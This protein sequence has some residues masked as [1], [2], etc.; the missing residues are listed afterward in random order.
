[1]TLLAHPK[2]SSHL[3]TRPAQ[4]NAGFTI[5][6]M[7][8][9][10]TIAGFMLA[11]VPLAFSKLIETAEYRATVR[12]LQS[13]LKDARSTAL[14]QGRPVSY[15]VDAQNGVFGVEGDMNNTVP[16]HLHLSLVMAS[17][18]LTPEGAGRFIFFPD[19]G[20]TGGSVEILRDA[21]D[22]VRLRVDWLLGRISQETL[23][24][25]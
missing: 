6:E 5:L 20:A 11:A 13:G 9:V 17:E 21:D 1:M 18:N 24:Q 22:G 16:K 25:Q 15:L 8:V 3:P 7:I 4:Q 14:A 12:E 23:L 2:P 10:L 19:G